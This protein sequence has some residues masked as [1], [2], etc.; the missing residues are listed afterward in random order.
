MKDVLRHDGNGGAQTVLGHPANALIVDQNSA[1]IDVGQ[2]LY[3]ADQGRLASSRGADKTDPLPR[4]DAQV[5]AIKHL[6]SG[7]VR[8]VDIVELDTAP[9][10][11]QRPRS[12][13]VDHPVIL[14]DDLDR[15]GDAGD[16]LR[17]VDQS[18]GEVARAVQYAKRHRQGQDHVAG[19]NPPLAPQMQCPGEHAAGHEPER[20]I[21]QH[22][23]ALDVH[24]TIAMR[25]L[26]DSQKPLEPAALPRA[27]RK[28]LDHP[29][30]GE[31]VDQLAAD[32]GGTIGMIAVPRHA[33][34]AE[35][36]QRARRHQNKAK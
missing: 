22:A 1:T 17:R 14:A 35:P 27:R 24:Q 25:V 6:V 23:H 28:G 31:H 29:D 18:K 34:L 26:L 7:R 3:Q 11:D 19:T 20:E 9:E 36:N 15:I 33:A 30:V 16:E 21:V 5:E 2:P 10:M 4:L 32:F 12:R 13:L 8:K